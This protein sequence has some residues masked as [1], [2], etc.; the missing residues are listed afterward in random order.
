MHANKEP[1]SN[2]LTIS[3]IVRV[4]VVRIAKILAILA[5]SFGW[6]VP[7]ELGLS[8]CVEW[9]RRR[10]P[11]SETDVAY[12]RA[13]GLLASAWFSLVAVTY[14]LV[15][16]NQLFVAGRAAI[17]HFATRPKRM[18]HLIIHD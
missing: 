1:V 4:H 9:M 7:M 14:V 3:T 13:C 18:R 10:T 5:L 11:V 2:R 8:T 12:V 15:A 6:I 16:V 17:R